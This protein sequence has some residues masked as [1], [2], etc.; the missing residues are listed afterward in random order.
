[1]RVCLCVCMDVNTCT[2]NITRVMKSRTVRLVVQVVR[3]TEIRT[4]HRNL[5]GKSEKRI[6]FRGFKM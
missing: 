2:P 1:M 4:V 5:V 6:P 3:I